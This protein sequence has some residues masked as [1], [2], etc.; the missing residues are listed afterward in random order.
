MNVRQRR[1]V[2]AR[3]REQCHS[4]TTISACRGSRLS[5]RGCCRDEVTSLGRAIAVRQMDIG[6]GASPRTM[7]P[8]Y[9]DLS[10]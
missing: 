8:P 10:S 7:S 5:S 2:S 6:L 3:L 9:N 4:H 1:P